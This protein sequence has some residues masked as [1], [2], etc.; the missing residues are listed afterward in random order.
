MTKK[1]KCRVKGALRP[2]RHLFLVGIKEP[3]Y[4]PLPIWERYQ[5]GKIKTHKAY[6]FTLVKD[7]YCSGQLYIKS[8]SYLPVRLRNRRGKKR[9]GIDPIR[10]L[11]SL[12][13]YLIK[14]H[15][16]P[17]SSW[18]NKLQTQK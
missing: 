18:K 11:F 17:L 5:K 2:Y 6:R 12:V 8:I 15:K 13:V 3:V 9:K 4:M 10:F 1:C 14:L 7:G 16:F